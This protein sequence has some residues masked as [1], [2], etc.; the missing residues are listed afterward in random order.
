M[1]ED[2]KNTDQTATNAELVRGALTGDR[3]A[4]ERL[5]RRHD[6]ALHRVARSFRVDQATAE[7]AVQTA[8]LRLVEHMDALREPERVGSWLITTVRRQISATA[9][10]YRRGPRLVGLD[11]ADPAG[12][13]RSPE[14][15]VTEGELG[16]Q[17]KAALGRL[18]ARNR[19]LLTL[20]MESDLSYREVSAML[21]MP[22]GSIGPVR[23]RS[24][25]LLR[26][27]LA[28]V[29]IDGDALIA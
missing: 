20:L 15:L 22:V 3:D 4:W 29:G 28:A 26:R 11:G 18:P 8:W 19:T 27:E 7:D 23:A 25:D 1:T 14:E 6:A 9:P 10:H 12:P 17:T 13:D 2:G 5:V 16:V 24:L 21:H